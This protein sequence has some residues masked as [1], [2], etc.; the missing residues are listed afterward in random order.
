LSVQDVVSLGRLPFQSALHP[1]LSAEDEAIIT[2]ALAEAGMTAFRNRRFDTLSGGEQ[3]RVHIARALAQ[4][5]KLL[6]LDEPTSHLDIGAQMDLFTLLHRR[7]EAGLTVVT[8]LHDLNLASRCDHIVL[9]KGGRVMTEGVPQAVLTT[10]LLREAYGVEARLL[11]DPISGRPVIVYD[12]G[13]ASVSP[14]NPD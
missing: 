2:A 10:A 11:T 12:H 3:Q 1:D 14:S 7:A 9:L 4:Q 5:P 6:L 8:A 13:P